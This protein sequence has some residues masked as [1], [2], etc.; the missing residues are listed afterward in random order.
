MDPNPY[1]LTGPASRPKI[2]LL[3]P[4]RSPSTCSAQD[5]LRSPGLVLSLCRPRVLRSCNARSSRCCVPGV[6]NLF[7]LP[8]KR[9]L[10][11]QATDLFWVLGGFF[12]PAPHHFPCR[13]ERWGRALRASTSASYHLPTGPP[14]KEKT[15]PLAWPETGLLVLLNKVREP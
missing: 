2:Y 7:R 6:V 9:S 4:G 8:S 11:P 14:V 12:H 10:R 3:S 5:A 1:S 13:R 15:S